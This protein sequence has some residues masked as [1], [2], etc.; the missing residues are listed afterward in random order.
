LIRAL[1]VHA[2]RPGGQNAGRGGG[3][4]WKTK[5]WE[6]FDFKARSLGELNGE[7]LISKPCLVCSG[8]NKTMENRSLV[9]AR[10]S[11]APNLVL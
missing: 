7:T 4:L 2:A 8:L 11:K 3:V 9:G 10:G 1:H 6:D 5:K